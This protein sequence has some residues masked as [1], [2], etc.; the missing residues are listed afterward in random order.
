MKGILLLTTTISHG[1]FSAPQAAKNRGL[2][3]SVL[4]TDLINDVRICGDVWDWTVRST[5]F[6]LPLMCSLGSHP[7]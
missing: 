4:L 7:C 6:L 2:K 5:S 1:S 3:L